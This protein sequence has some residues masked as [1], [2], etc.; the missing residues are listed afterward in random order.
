M[1]QPKN[2]TLTAAARHL[3]VRPSRISDGERGIRRLDDLTHTYRD[4]LQTA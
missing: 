1:R 2:I 4:W 3:G